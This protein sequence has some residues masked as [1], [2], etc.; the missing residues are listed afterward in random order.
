GLA[1]GVEPGNHVGR[2]GEHLTADVGGDAAHAVVGGREDGDRLRVRLHTQVGA[3][4]LGDV[5][6][7][8]ID[9]RGLE[10]GQVEVDV[11]LVRT[12]AAT[13]AHLVGHRARHDVARGEVLQRGG[14]ALH[15]ALHLAVAQDAA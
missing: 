5:R 7:L 2:V 12:G 14:V 1:R 8:R 11:V 13:L 3:G 15:E 4:E 9:V 10:V 6:E